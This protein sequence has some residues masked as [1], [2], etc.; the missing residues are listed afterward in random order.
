[1]DP[2]QLFW[3]LEDQHVIELNFR[4]SLCL[5]TAVFGQQQHQHQSDK[6]ILRRHGDYFLRR[7]PSSPSDKINKLLSKN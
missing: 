4:W 3:I 7:E 1:M 5:L 2:D 6:D